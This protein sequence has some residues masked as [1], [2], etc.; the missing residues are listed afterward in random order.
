MKL[1]ILCVPKWLKI[2][3]FSL[4]G[5]TKLRPQAYKK[6]MARRRVGKFY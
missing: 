2:S 6:R 4:K 1:V 5:N 3:I